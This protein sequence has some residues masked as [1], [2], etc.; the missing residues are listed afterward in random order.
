MALTTTTLVE[1]TIQLPVSAVDTSFTATRGWN[2]ATGIELNTNLAGTAARYFK[3]V[4]FSSTSSLLNLNIVTTAAG[5]TTAR[6]LPDFESYGE[7]EITIG[8]NTWTFKTNAKD[9]EH[10]VTS[11]AFY[12]TNTSDL[13]E[14]YNAISS[15]TSATLKFRIPVLKVDT[16]TLPASTWLTPNGARFGWKYATADRPAIDELFRPDSDEKYL[17][18]FVVRK[19]RDGLLLFIADD[20]TTATTNTSDDTL[21]DDFIDSGYIEVKKKGTTNGTNLFVLPLELVD[22]PDA[23][24]PYRFDFTDARIVSLFED[25]RDAIQDDLVD[26]TDDKDIEVKFVLPV[27]SSEEVPEPLNTT[28]FVL[29]TNFDI[30][31]E[32]D[33]PTGITTDGTYLYVVDLTDKKVYVHSLDGTRQADRDF[34]LDSSTGFASGITYDKTYIYILDSSGEKIFVYSLDGTRQSTR[35]FDLA[36]SNDNPTGITT[37]GTYLYVVD[38]V[39]EKVYV[40]SLDGTRQ[41]SRDFNLDSGNT[42][43][44]DITTDGTYLYVIDWVDRQ[45][46]VYSID[47]TRQSSR[48]FDFDTFKRSLFGITTNGTFIYTLNAD[49]DKI[50]IYGDQ[51]KL[52]STFSLPVASFEGE[53]TTT[54]LDIPL[55]TANFELLG[56]FGLDFNNTR[57]TGIDTDGTYLYVA[58]TDD[59][60][61]YV[62]N[63]DVTRPNPSRDFNLDSNNSGPSSMYSD[64][65]YLYVVDNADGKV[66]AYS[67]DG[68]RQ[69]SRDFNFANINDIASGLTYDGTYFYV[70]DILDDKVYVYSADGTRQTT[71]EFS[72]D[73][74]ISIAGLT[75]DGTYLYVVDAVDDKVFVYSLDGTRQSTRDFNLDSD[76]SSPQGITIDGTY[77]Y[78]IDSDDHVYIYGIPPR[79]E[80][81]LTLPTANFT[82]EV[83]LIR[84]ELDTANF[85][86]IE[87]FDLNNNNGHPRG[88]TTDG[89]YFYVSD[90]NDGKIYVY[91]LDGT[92]RSA[93]DFDLD[94]SNPLPVGTTTDRTY[95][96]VVNFGIRKVFVY[97]LDG[98]RQS[99][100]DFNLDGENGLP[101]GITTDGTYLYVIDSSDDK[102]YVYSLDG[103]RQSSRDFNLD[104]DN[105]DPT[106]ITTDGTY[107][108]VVDAVDDKVYVHSLD[109][110]R[111]SSRDFNLDSDNGNPTG[112]NYYGGYLYFVVQ[113]D[114]K[115]YAYG[116]PT[117]GPTKI[118]STGTL[119]VATF[120]GEVT[121]TAPAT[122]TPLDTPN[123]RQ[124]RNFNLI[125]DNSGPGGI[126]T[127]GTYLYVADFFRRGSIH[128]FKVYVYNLD[129]TRPDPSRDFNLDRD[130]NNSS[131]QGI[132]TDGTYLYVSNRQNNKVY[133]YSLDGTRQS[134]R[135]F[136]L[137]SDN[138]Q[139]RGITTD[140]NYLYVVDDNVADNKVYVYSLDGTRQST[141]D[142]DLDSGNIGSGGITTDGTYLYVVDDIDNKVYVYSLGG[143]RQSSRDFDLVSNNDSQSGITTDGTFVY[144]ITFS[145]I[146]SDKIHVYGAPT[147]LESTLSLPVASSDIE[148]IITNPPPEYELIEDLDL[149][150]TN[151]NPQGIATDGTYLY[152]TDLGQSTIFSYDF[153]GTRQTTQEFSRQTNNQ[154]PR[155]ITF[156][157]NYFWIVDNSDDLVYSHNAD[158]TTPSISRTFALFSA[159][160]NPSG[161]TS[162]GTYLYVAQFTGTPAVYAYDV[163]GN[164][165][166]S[167]Y[168]QLHSD[169]TGPRGIAFDGTNLNVIDFTQD[170]VFVYDTDG[171]R[172][173]NLEFDLH[174]GNAVCQGAVFH[175]D[176]LYI[177]DNSSDK[178][179]VYGDV[180]V[181]LTTTASLPVATFSGEVTLGGAL[182]KNYL[183]RNL[184]H[185]LGTNVSFNGFSVSASIPA[186]ML[187]LSSS[188]AID[189]L[190]LSNDSGNSISVGI[191]LEPDSQGRRPDFLSRIENSEVLFILE[192]GDLS[193]TFP[194]PN[195]SG[196]TRRDSGAH[197]SYT[198]DSA[199]VKQF[200]SD[201]DALTGT[202]DVILCIWDGTQNASITGEL[203][204]PVLNSDIELDVV[205]SEESLE[206]TTLEIGALEFDSVATHH[207][208]VL[209]AIDTLETTALEFDSVATHHANVLPAINTL[210]IGS[211]EFDGKVQVPLDTANFTLL[212]GFNLSDGNN[213]PRG[214]TTDGTYI[215]IADTVD[216]KIYV[217]NLDGTRQSSR[218]FNLDSTNTSAKGLGIYDN[219]LYVADDVA[220][221]IFVYSL[222][223]TRQATKDVSLTNIR[224]GGISTNLTFDILNV[225]GL[226]FNGND[227]Y[228]CTSSGKI[229]RFSFTNNWFHQDGG[230]VSGTGGITTDGTYIYSSNRVQIVVYAIGSA[231]NSNNRL[232]DREITPA[233]GNVSNNIQGITTDG[234]Y[235][236]AIQAFATDRVDVFGLPTKLEGTLTLPTTSFDGELTATLPETR[237][238]QG[239]LNLSTTD[240]DGEVTHTSSQNLEGALT[241]PVATFDGKVS[242]TSLNR[243][244]ELSTL[245]ITSLEFDSV[246]THHANVLP[247]ID[248][249]EVT[250]LEFDSV[251]THHANVL[252][253]IDTLEVGSLEIDEA[254]LNQKIFVPI[255]TTSDDFRLLRRFDL[256][257]AN[258][259]PQGMTTDGTYIY[260]VDTVD[261]KVYVHSIDG[262]RQSSKDFDLISANNS[263]FSITTDGTYIYVS[264]FLD[265]DV[266][267]YNLDGTRPDP[268]RD[269]N[270]VGGIGNPTGMTTDGDYIYISTSSSGNKVF[271]Y[272]I[273]GT[274]Q[275][276]RD[277]RLNSGNN[278]SAGMAVDS[279]YIYVVDQLNGKVFVYSKNGTYESARN[280]D[281][282][283]DNSFSSGMT[284]DGNYL[285]VVD[286]GDDEV[287]VY[288]VPTQFEATAT[289]PVGTFEGSLEVETKSSL[290]ATLSLPVASFSGSITHSSSISIPRVPRLE[291]D[292]LEFDS[293]ATHHANVLPAIDTLEVTELEFD[294]VATHHANVLP[295]IDTLEV[296]E[297]ELVASL[298]LSDNVTLAATLSLPISSVDA[299]VTHSSKAAVAGTISLPVA[300]FTG[301]A[302][303]SS[304]ISIPRVPRLEIDALEFD[305]VATHHAN[306]LPTIDTLE[307]T[308]L[309]LTASLTISD[310]EGLQATLSLP[311]VSID[312][313]VTHTSGATIA[314]TFSLPV[315]TFIGFATHGADFS[316]SPVVFEIG[317]LEFD[318]VATH[319][320]NSL[321]E[322]DTLEIDKLELDSAS[323]HH[324][325]SLPE[326]DVL[327][328]GSVELETSLTH[329]LRNAMAP[330][331]E[332]VAPNGNEGTEVTLT[333]RLTGGV[334][335]NLI[336]FWSVLEGTTI[337]G[338]DVSSS[339]INNRNLATPTFTRP[340][341]STDA[342]YIISL[343]IIATGI[344]TKARSGTSQSVSKIVT[345]RVIADTDLELSTLEVGS[346]EFDSVATHHAN[347][348]P[349]IDTLEITALEFD[350]VA[351]HHANAVPQLDTLE[352]G[353]IEL[354]TSASISKDTQLQATISLPISDFSASTIHSSNTTATPS[355]LEIGALEFDSVA[356]HHAN[357]LPAIDTLEVTE[358]EFD[359]LAT[360][361]ANSVP[362][363]DILEIEV[364]IDEPV[365]VIGER[366]LEAT[367]SL[368]EVIVRAEAK[369]NERAITA[370]IVLPTTIFD[371]RVIQEGD[372]DINAV[373]SLPVA[374]FSG[375]ITHGGNVTIESTFKLPRIVSDIS[376]TH[377]NN[378]SFNQLTTFEIDALEFDSVATHHAN[379]LPQID[380]LEID[381]LEF[382]SVATHHAHAVPEIDILE[383]TELEFES[384]ATH[385]ST[386]TAQ[387]STLEITELEFDSS[388]THGKPLNLS[389]FNTL[390]IGGLE[391]DT[392]PLTHSIAQIIAPSTLETGALEFDSVATHHAHAVPEIDILE[393]TELEF[394]SSLSLGNEVEFNQ[395]VALET[396]ALEFESSLTHT[397]DV[398]PVEAEFSLPVSAF[399]STARVLDPEDIR[400]FPSRDFNLH[401]A[402]QDPHGVTSDGTYLYVVDREDGEVYVYN[403]DGEVYVYNLDGNRPNPSRNFA[404]ND[405][406]D[407]AG[408]ITIA[409]SGIYV[410][411]EDNQRVYIYNL[412]GTYRSSFNIISNN[413]AHGI[414]NDGNYIYTLHRVDN[415]VDDIH[416][417]N[418]DGTRPD[419]SRDFN[420]DSINKETEGIVIVDSI[421]YTLDNESGDIYAYGLDGTRAED[422]DFELIN[423]EDD[424]IEYS[425]V[426][427]DGNYFYMVSS[428]KKEIY[429][430]G[431][432]VKL[433]KSTGSLP[434]ATLTGAVTYTASTSLEA[435][436][437]LPIVS[438]DVEI[439]HTNSTTLEPSTLEIDELELD[440]SI[441]DL[442]K[443]EATLSLPISTFSA[444]ATATVLVIPEYALLEDL[445]LNVLNTNAQGIATDG[446][447]LYVPDLNQS[448]IYAYDFDGTRQTTQEFSRQAANQHPRGIVFDGT[449]FWIIDNNDDVVYS[450]DADGSTPLISRNFTLSTANNNPSGITSDGTYLYV[451]QFTGTP[452]VFVYDTSGNE[453]TTRRFDL[454]SDND[455]PRGI[456]FDGTNLNVIDFN[457]DKL[458]VYDTDGNRQEDEEFDL[459]I[460]NT[461]PQGVVYHD[462]KYYIVDNDSNKIHVYEDTRG[463]AELE[464]TL[465]L[466][467][468]TFSG[469]FV[470]SSPHVRNY[471]KATFPHIGGTNVSFNGFDVNVPLPAYVLS[472]NDASSL[473]S[474]TLE[475]RSGN[476]I[477]IGIGI[478]FLLVGIGYRPDLID[479]IENDGAAFI[480][481][482]GNLSITIPGPNFSGNRTRDNSAGYQYSTESPE[483]KQ[484]I[485]D[486]NDLANDTEVT[487]CVWDG[488]QTASIMGELSI[489]ALTSD[490][491][492]TAGLVPDVLEIGSLEFDSVLT[493]HTNVSPVID[494]L[495]VGELEFDGSAEWVHHIEPEL[496]IIEIGDVE[497]DVAATIDN[498]IELDLF[499]IEIADVELSDV[500][501]PLAQETDVEIPVLEVGDVEL[502][503]VA[504]HH[505]HVLPAIDTLE[506]GDVE[507]DELTHGTFGTDSDIFYLNG[508]FAEPEV[509]EVGEITFTTGVRVNLFTE[510]KFAPSVFELRRL[511][512]AALA[513]HTASTDFTLN[514][515]EVS[516]L[517]LETE[518]S[519]DGM[520]VLR[521]DD[522]EIGEIEIDAVSLDFVSGVT[523]SLFTLELI[524][525]ELDTIT[526][527]H[528]DEEAIEGTLSLPVANFEGTADSTYRAIEAILRLPILRS[529]NATLTVKVPRGLETTLAL[530]PTRFTTRLNTRVIDISEL[531]DADAGRDRRVTSGE[532]V[533]LGSEGATFFQGGGLQYKWKQLSGPPITLNSTTSANPT[534]T[535][536][537]IP[538][539]ND[540]GR[541]SVGARGR[542]I[543]QDEGIDDIYKIQERADTL[544]GRIILNLVRDLD[545]AY[546][547]DESRLAIAP[548]DYIPI[549]T[550]KVPTGITFREEVVPGQDGINV[551]ATW[552]NPARNNGTRII[553]SI[554]KLFIY[555]DRIITE[556]IVEGNTFT[557]YRLEKGIVLTVRLYGR[558]DGEETDGYIEASHLVGTGTLGITGVL[559]ALP[560]VI[561]YANGFITIYIKSGENT[562]SMDV[563]VQ[564]GTEYEPTTFDTLEQLGTRMV[565]PESREVLTVPAWT[566][567]AS[568]ER[569]YL[570]GTYRIYI[571]SLGKN[572]EIG[573]IQSGTITI[574]ITA[575]DVD[576][577]IDAG[578]WEGTIEG[579]KK[580]ADGDRFVLIPESRRTAGN[581]KY[582]EWETDD[583][584]LVFARREITGV[585]RYT[586]PW[587]NVNNPDGKISHTFNV[588]TDFRS[589][590]DKL[591]EAGVTWRVEYKGEESEGS[592]LDIIV[593]G[594]E[595][596]VDELHNYE[597]ESLHLLSSTQPNL[598]AGG[599]ATENHVP[600]PWTR[601]KPRVTVDKDVWRISRRKKT[602]KADGSFISASAWGALES[603]ERRTGSS[604]YS[605]EGTF[606][607][608]GIDLVGTLSVQHSSG[609]ALRLSK[610]QLNINEGSSGTFN[611]RLNTQP[612][613]TVTVFLTETSSDISLSSTRLTFT[614]TNWN[615]AQTVTVSAAQDVDSSDEVATI[616]ISASGGGYNVASTEE[617][618]VNIND[619]EGGGTITPVGTRGIS[620]SRS[621]ISVEE[622]STEDFTVVLDAVPTG[623]VTIAVN[624]SSAKISVNKTSLT[625]TTS[626]WNSEQT[627][628]ITG[629]QD[630]DIDNNT[631]II[632][633]IASGGGYGNV[634]DQIIR[635]NIIDDDVIKESAEASLTLPVATFTGEA[636]G[637]IVGIEFSSDDLSINVFQNIFS[638]ERGVGGVLKIHL[639]SQPSSTVTVNISIT[640]GGLVSPVEVT[641]SPTR[642]T[643][644]TSNWETD[645]EINLTVPTGTRTTQATNFIRF[646]ISGGGEYN[647]LFRFWTMIVESPRQPQNSPLFFQSPSDVH[648][649]DEITTTD[650]V[651][652]NFEMTEWRIRFSL[653]LTDVS[654]S[655]YFN[656]FLISHKHDVVPF[657]PD[658]E[659]E[660]DLASDFFNGDLIDPDDAEPGTYNNYSGVNGN[661][662]L[663]YTYDFGGLRYQVWL[664]SIT[665][666]SWRR[667]RQSDGT[668]GPWEDISIPETFVV[669][670][671]RILDG[672]ITEL[673]L[674]EQ[675]VTHAKLALDAVNADNILDD[676][677]TEGKIA[678]NAITGDKIQEKTITGTLISDKAITGTL[679]A[680]QTLTGDLIA[681]NTVT[682][683]LIAN[684][685]ITGELISPRTITGSLIAQNAIVGDL[686]ASGSITASKLAALSITGDIIAGNTITAMHMSSGSIVLNSGVVNGVLGA[687]HLDADVQNVRPLWS[688]RN[689]LI[690]NGIVTFTLGGDVSLGD[691]LPELSGRSYP[692]D[693]LYGIA[694]PQQ[695]GVNDNEFGMWGIYVEDIIKGGSS[696]A[697]NGVKVSTVVT[698]STDSN[699]GHVRIWRNSIGN[700]I[701]M[702]ADQ[703]NEGFYIY[704]IIAVRNPSNNAT[705]SASGSPTG[706]GVAG[707]TVTPT[708]LSITEGD[709]G[710]FTVKLT[711]RPT[712]TV[713]VALTKTN[714]DVSLSPTSISFT[715]SN[716]NTAKTISVN[717]G[718]DTDTTNDTDTITINPSGGGYDSVSNSTVSVVILDDDVVAGDPTA[719]TAGTPTAGTVALSWTAVAGAA[720]Y[721]VHYSKNDW[722]SLGDPYQEFTSNSGTLSGLES[723]TDYWLAI[724]VLT[725]DGTTS[726]DVDY[727]SS[728]PT[729]ELVA[730]DSERSGARTKITTAAGSGSSVANYYAL[731]TTT[732]PRPTST[733]GLL[734]S[735]PQPTE[736]QNVYRITVVTGTNTVVYGLWVKIA[737]ATGASAVPATP[738]WPKIRAVVGRQFKGFYGYV[739]SFSCSSG[740][741]F[742]AVQY[743][744][745]MS[746]KNSGFGSWTLSGN[747]VSDLTSPFSITTGNLPKESIFQQLRF[748]V[749]VRNARG[750]S[751]WSTS[752]SP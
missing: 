116:V 693:I 395:L 429:S 537:D 320:A 378:V 215:Y 415:N 192:V 346:L 31:S 610:T 647:G 489:P 552:T 368:P 159:N 407:K 345:T 363:L 26:G 595:D 98:T 73:T 565:S 485:S 313:T 714:A 398:E 668:W 115:V 423:D 709:F 689:L 658:E 659:I 241:L 688:G 625:F 35:E 440:S 636:T 560:P 532:A 460:S 209:P 439:T 338:K 252:P 566:E 360:H 140:G 663:F 36:S 483:I 541:F 259:S 437:S 178:I 401:A 685:T 397:I 318:S 299:S 472:G 173:E 428:N 589:L 153:D 214:I 202:P 32:N 413:N 410:V 87:E 169:N 295:A 349:A 222:D 277:F 83:D 65:T 286:D 373:L 617:I 402:N 498:S 507:L 366:S 717:V 671:Q 72:Y 8:D 230:V 665:G 370:T 461:K 564:D 311:V 350:S 228:V 712:A 194:G 683:N 13:T 539:D 66:Y 251:A 482:A 484:F 527:T 74:N 80:G 390:E 722:V 174:S 573:E 417:Y 420:L 682:G 229:D 185:V 501:L 62:Y 495:E 505:A 272:N 191:T 339:T 33:N 198:I 645:Q 278:F 142:F 660:I 555:D 37:D 118:E 445:D 342:N 513:E 235:I 444:E 403:L 301:S 470:I 329:G 698:G 107:L 196:N 119:P 170:K 312:A 276:D 528:M 752:V 481:E 195:Y 421:L 584:G 60:K 210:E 206:L 585:G 700:R 306:S 679:I 361:H 520:F 720:K 677:I 743:R 232:D 100:R 469:T 52:E 315:A 236:Y 643:F 710:Q 745:A 321:P 408:G 416:V 135:D 90:S 603:I 352:I 262:T 212:R 308:E 516:E 359:S 744:Y 161:I 179:H 494:T 396:S 594:N 596:K 357:V 509:I 201:Y 95:I 344:G 675:A 554:A 607:G 536:P 467:V 707:L 431:N 145:V 502:E 237:Q 377:S 250:S 477:G 701:Y 718:Q 255:D 664:D 424:D 438:S 551:T 337:L 559:A 674:G 211:L 521:G 697:P 25:F 662:G 86:L 226:T 340:Q 79:P 63:L 692:A 499:Q 55:D 88:L 605:L 404:L 666:R 176:K 110:T 2:L 727:D 51:P 139:S 468:A 547:K 514:T 454:H 455:G 10:S 125:N 578:N 631:A 256:D 151:T 58:D 582:N 581:I 548:I 106:G 190:T 258:G 708:S 592:K 435:T 695:A 623:D 621:T 711:T 21:S 524:E 456:T 471:L 24:E 82:V 154:H 372:L 243:T 399:E 305:S 177:V 205:D 171:N 168:F 300:S 549:F 294:S 132:T 383:V 644:T 303:H 64:G 705:S 457:E 459:H 580:V 16:F 557:W 166:S 287:Y 128:D 530:P 690:G 540:I 138:M 348:L 600:N 648:T 249:L 297:L 364:E 515:L 77:L 715:T 526:L 239:T 53:A 280:F 380:T 405:G 200:I 144:V 84:P 746:M 279:T 425:G 365:L 726:P 453:Q 464:S 618:I 676:A 358:L 163:D 11:Y 134:S 283:R 76:N 628:T 126:T 740:E 101:D 336:Y 334:Y 655:H 61:V 577:V 441:V 39:D 136:N 704:S 104:S 371:G 392:V 465:T 260:V 491:E 180:G 442:K 667:I 89:N 433:L 188:S 687:V 583:A 732:P 124:L 234:T 751:E 85:V 96:Y 672:A 152:V 512:L 270:L 725:A 310:T 319:H 54:E 406:N 661:P 733:S 240:F 105:G 616:S 479:R 78:V 597:T 296:T 49:D 103:T 213:D 650:V 615:Q 384:S 418:L 612:S 602:L 56:K 281:L 426:S 375:S 651:I 374:T 635:V 568:G 633:L 19:D 187:T 436:I 591:G 309:E 652:D 716:W 367:L 326:I 218:D 27:T 694:R 538:R 12:P 44:S 545:Q 233:G 324:A 146:S 656:D 22:P 614:T 181:N 203:S 325:N 41:S 266:Y 511:E 702:Q 414:A 71:R 411:N 376:L 488:T 608:P 576:P 331:V 606:R 219:D 282:I 563:R 123:F 302:T 735:Q 493:H 604:P 333:T 69:S 40:H 156:D 141:R 719:P 30:D 646:N 121:V 567:T 14:V 220:N 244:P 611:V 508:I 162:D 207:A 579:F 9:R 261:D 731:G 706:S 111:Q 534:F 475:V 487:I 231:F 293:V 199:E 102:V 593:I 275:A 630:V 1:Q 388:L 291:I 637:S 238:L 525:L 492:L 699:S 382:D 5:N 108:Y 34:N 225:S 730:N 458:F 165:Q 245:E 114:D 553:A 572:G 443:V 522:L 613:G 48:D 369:T 642:L 626:N 556:T 353:E 289:L 624:E 59:D 432:F 204:L 109:G 546:E 274:R 619:D 304:S 736:T 92:Y 327:E 193:V 601:L 298:S 182:A 474:F 148:L 20:L 355:T 657:S 221:N 351:T 23:T 686:I 50:Y 217:Y 653:D 157:G 587:Y 452:A 269:F 673:K 590:V 599:H 38:Q 734:T 570:E 447:Y 523:P 155:G 224:D 394:E 216:N 748:Q 747:V 45:L 113:S 81:T 450:Y 562:Y 322:I 314:G 47:G 598:P 273:N 670:T 434:V 449:Y 330:S 112:I 430:Y 122:T 284:S 332:I 150:S 387:L 400:H 248:T 385:T 254:E 186:Y 503:S 257:S 127:D 43:P 466:P 703:S 292:A 271:V 724:V 160:D 75:Y 742:T 6:L 649:T 94:N 721:R 267:V 28:D 749:R 288:G 544:E 158:G 533:T 419:T 328:I 691:I 18:Q 478:E 588:D 356:T 500:E 490:I 510:S 133:V 750:W 120:G 341:V 627:I 571:R 263:P 223:G 543:V 738:T 728:S 684:R 569:S 147:K 446:S 427:Y 462:E 264:D 197:Y 629:E 91:S 517:E 317:A 290:K 639:S 149:H 42:N 46:Y 529:S 247:A 70:G 131:P 518:A 335:D 535:A 323:T 641:A 741:P 729:S 343:T 574:T 737:D 669:D 519:A 347:V 622:G 175:N 723:A 189:S 29:L 68:T 632:D 504:T 412:D 379:S 550:A 4:Y 7:I 451:A 409:S 739:F 137:D 164:V 389:Q 680:D 473:D 654:N 97:N 253:A 129:G 285:Y 130:N 542:V 422:L 246:A 678:R 208:N 172:L 486:Y 713:S 609:I 620:V 117:G 575:E 362:Q 586:T 391:L 476:I 381:E 638:I 696:S 268:S 227:L 448:T 531:P 463:R 93:R 265:A 393:V 15:S 143:N 183:K 634:T 3:S 242:P 561:F 386:S 480:I 506:I 354:S 497:L 558:V 316:M 307:V 184:G 640:D 496:D 67:L 681:E 57:A 99:S 17:E 167:K